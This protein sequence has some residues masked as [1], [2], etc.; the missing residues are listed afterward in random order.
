M[1][2]IL[3]LRALLFD[4]GDVIYHRPRR[5]ARL[6]PF[7]AQMGL[8]KTAPDAAALAELKRQAHAGEISK[9]QY[10]DE[11]LALNGVSGNAARLA[12]RRILDD[13]Q[14]DVEFFAG[15]PETLRRLKAAGLRLGIVT[16][17]FD[18]TA[19]KL[20][21]FKRVGIDDLWDSFA[22]SCELKVCKPD[23][24]IYLA[25]L[26]PLGVRA[27]HAGFVG[28]AAAELQGAKDLGLVTIAFNRDDP[29]V[30]ADHI[31]AE[32]SDLLPLVGL[33]VYAVEN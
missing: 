9:K 25:A 7:L 2:A 31:I 30:P 1:T 24:R 28:H 21:W 11:V 12:G 27:D 19:D 4:A 17:T 16:N 14:R 3:N 5:G 8:P 26:R 29:A 18:A 13:E 23:A 6:K 20:D 22:T 10:Q 33:G 32:F 15:V